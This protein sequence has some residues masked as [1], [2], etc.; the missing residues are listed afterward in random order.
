M[1]K[2]LITAALFG[3]GVI[4][5]TFSLGGCSKQ[6]LSRTPIEQMLPSKLDPTISFRP[7]RQD[8]EL[9]RQCFRAPNGAIEK[10][11]VPF[12]TG[13]RIVFTYWT[14][15]QGLGTVHTVQEFYP[16]AK[17]GTAQRLNRTVE[18]NRAGAIVSDRILRLDQSLQHKGDMVKELYETYDYQIDGSV[19]AHRQIKNVSGTWKLWLEQTFYPGGNTS[20]L[21]STEPDG[22]TFTSWYREDKT[23]SKTITGDAFGG[24]F[25][26]S[27]Y[28]ADGHS[29]TRT[30]DERWLNVVVTTYKNGKVAEKRYWNY[31]FIR[32]I[33]QTMGVTVYDDNGVPKFTQLWTMNWSEVS[34]FM[35]KAPKSFDPAMY[36][37]R[38][39]MILNADG[40][41]IETISFY[42]DEKT[43]KS[44][45]LRPDP[46]KLNPR[47]D[48]DFR[49]DGTLEKLKEHDADG[50]TTKVE[51]HTPEENIREPLDD[52]WL[53]A[54]PYAD[55]PH[56]I[57][58]DHE[59]TTFEP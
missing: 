38:D 6:D 39:V 11:D 32:T 5:L 35:T 59:T 54:R 51:S 21:L 16:L 13:K 40:K 56:L 24:H 42:D 4:A 34:Q 43:P 37:L 8:R 23:L 48:K 57:K 36:H 29:L 2:R 18:R 45:Q 25:V 27:E 52:A 44:I 10:C 30:V 22:S 49:A 53:K 33:P 41:T 12:E 19:A 20:E 47:T 46:E 55:P 15:G 1:V 26:T 3:A 31:G 14:D 28:E 50:N 9:P 58:R 7:N 17:D